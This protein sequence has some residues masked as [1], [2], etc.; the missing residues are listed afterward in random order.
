MHPPPGLHAIAQQQF[1]RGPNY[2]RD[3]RQVNNRKRGPPPPQQGYPVPYTTGPAAATMP[4]FPQ[5]G[6]YP[7]PGYFAPGPMAPPSGY[8]PAA[9]MPAVNNVATGAPSYRQPQHD[10]RLEY[11]KR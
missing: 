1:G 4:P 10:P 11:N 6:F 2:Y 9:M 3:D 8:P 7:S 5:Q